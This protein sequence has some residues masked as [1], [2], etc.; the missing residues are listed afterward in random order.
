MLVAHSV[1]SKPVIKN[2]RKIPHPCSAAEESAT[3]LTGIRDDVYCSYIDLRACR[4]ARETFL[5]TCVIG[6]SGTPGALDSADR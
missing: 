4:S 5:I 1:Y 3:S 2:K 6:Y